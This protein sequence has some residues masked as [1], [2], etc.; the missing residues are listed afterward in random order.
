V[1][2]P[3]QVTS[4]VDANGATLVWIYTTYREDPQ[5]QYTIDAFGR[6]ALQTYYVKTPIGQMIVSFANNAVISVIEH[7]TDP[8]S[9]GVVTN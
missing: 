3:A 2:S 4:R 5:Y 1:G 7:K 8:N 9:P 6:P